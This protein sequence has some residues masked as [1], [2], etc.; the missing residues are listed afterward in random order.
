MGRS[1]DNRGEAFSGEYVCCR[2][3]ICCEETCFRREKKMS[4]AR[5]GKC[6]PSRSPQALPTWSRVRM[7]TMLICLY[8]K[9]SLRR[10]YLELMGEP[11]VG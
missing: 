3:R 6:R 11:I 7:G 10:P 8:V 5:N 9:H 2:Y 4:L 1:V